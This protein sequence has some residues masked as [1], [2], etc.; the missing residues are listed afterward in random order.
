MKISKK[1]KIFMHLYMNTNIISLIVTEKNK[2]I[3]KKD[4]KTNKNLQVTYKFV[5]HMIHNFQNQ[6]QNSYK[7][8]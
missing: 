8:F 5:E 3:L 7:T 1:L 2:E 6:T 4:I